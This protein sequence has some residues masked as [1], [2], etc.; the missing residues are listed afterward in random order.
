MLNHVL[1]HQTVIG[2]EAKEQLEL[3]GE[4][5]PD[6]VI[7]PCGGGSNLGGIAFPFVPDAGVRLLAVEPLSC[8]TL[9]QGRFEY[10][11]GDRPDFHPA[12]ALMYTLG[13]DSCATR[14]HR[15]W[16]CA[17]TPLMPK[18]TQLG[19]VVLR[20]GDAPDPRGLLQVPRQV[21]LGGSEVVGG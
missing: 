21:P 14:S 15:R 13:H 11:Y 5:L 1:L 16:L 8:P 18:Y 4:R 20:E 12:H 7:A 10:D 2:L 17:I 6:V 19:P 9:T 3:A